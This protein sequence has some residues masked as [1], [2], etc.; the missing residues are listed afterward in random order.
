VQPSDQLEAQARRAELMSPDPPSGDYWLDSSLK[1]YEALR[2]ECLV[3]I[4]TQQTILGF[5][6]ATLGLVIG[7]G[8]G[9]Q[10][11]ISVMTF[12]LIFGL[13]VPLFSGTVLTIWS[14]EVLRMVRAGDAVARLEEEINN[15][16]HR[17]FGW[18]RP[19]LTWETAL[20]G[21]D[22]DQSTRRSRAFVPN[23]ESVVLAFVLI[24]G[25]GIAMAFLKD[26]DAGNGI[27]TS[28]W[29]FLGFS[30]A[31]GTL[32]GLFMNQQ[33]REANKLWSDVGPALAKVR[34]RWETPTTT[35]AVD[36]DV[37]L[38]AKPTDLPD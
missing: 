7:A 23:I 33:R 30:L 5:G 36:C 37:P 22:G 2:A 11:Q 6:I 1:E 27:A 17:E 15:Y 29:V 34:S 18:T 26:R 24:A 16:G 28:T 9:L 25:I 31:L 4:S 19:A 13:F 8:I 35:A 21:L 12:G 10:N 20:R 3:S 32:V 38:S 14:G